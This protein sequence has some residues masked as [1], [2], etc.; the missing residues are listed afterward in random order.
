MLRL[1]V[2]KK[3]EDVKFDFFDLN[4][5]HLPVINGHP[6][7]KTDIPC[8]QNFKEMLEIARKLSQGKRHVR[9]DLY[10]VNGKIYFGELTFFHLTGMTAFEP[11]EW[12]YK[13]GSY[14]NLP[15]D[16]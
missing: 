5:N 6:H 1:I 4:W 8:P 12:D 16:K 10:N 14:L 9:V 11:I 7:S 3:G 15:I 2:K 13:F